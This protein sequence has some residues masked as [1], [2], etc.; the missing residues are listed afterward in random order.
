MT[1]DFDNLLF[2]IGSRV[3]WL[4]LRSQGE[5]NVAMYH[6]YSGFFW[7]LLSVCLS[8]WSSWFLLIG[9]AWAVLVLVRELWI[10]RHQEAIKTR[11]D[12][13]TKTVGLSAML[14]HMK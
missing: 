8:R 3:S 14:F 13:L 4:A 1:L 5:A 12:I 6:V 9:A 10:E 7:A 2:R 11:T